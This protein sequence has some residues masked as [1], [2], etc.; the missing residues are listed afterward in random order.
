MAGKREKRSAEK[1]E[2]WLQSIQDSG[3][4]IKEIPSGVELTPEL[5]DKIY[6]LGWQSGKEA[7]EEYSLG[8]D[9]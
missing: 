1:T 3:G 4:Y 9:A 2:Q 6:W 7:G 8:L 5:V